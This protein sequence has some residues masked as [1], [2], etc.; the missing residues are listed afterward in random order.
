MTDTPKFT[1]S[2]RQFL[3]G[4][5]VATGAAATGKLVHAQAAGP[6][7]AIMEMQPWQQYLGPPPRRGCSALRRAP[8]PMRRM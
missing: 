2:R 1:Q 8:R 6:D 3:A 5:A 7:P 4:A